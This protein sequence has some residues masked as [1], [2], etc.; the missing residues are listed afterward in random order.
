MRRDIVHIYSS[1][2]SNTAVL[3]CQRQLN[4][5]DC[6][7]EDHAWSAFRKW[8]STVETSLHN[9]DLLEGF[10]GEALGQ[11][12]FSTPLCHGNNA[13]AGRP[14]RGRLKSRPVCSGEQRYLLAHG[15]VRS[16]PAG[17]PNAERCKAETIPR[18][19]RFASHKP[20]QRGALR[21]I[22]SHASMTYCQARTRRLVS[23]G[24]GALQIIRGRP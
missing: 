3:R 7:S 24:S 21:A 22:P 4:E 1:H 16:S 13:R 12:P 11:P 5:N 20:S 15:Q 9:L 18:S 10:E 23:S 8:S 2:P 14:S 19:T 6:S 17:R